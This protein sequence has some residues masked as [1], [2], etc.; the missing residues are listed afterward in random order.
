MRGKAISVLLM[1]GLL[2][3]VL[4]APAGPRAHSAGPS[5]LKEV[6][7]SPP[8]TGNQVLLRIGGPYSFSLIQ[9]GAD[10]FS[11]DLN[12]V[13]A[14]LATRTP[15]G[16]TGPVKSY[17]VIPFAPAEGRTATRVEFYLK[18]PQSIRVDK[19]Q[20]G[21]RLLLENTASETAP[22]FA[23]LPA[24]LPLRDVDL[25]AL[26]AVVPHFQVPPS[27]I[28]HVAIRRGK[29]GQ[30]VVEI[31]TT[32]QSPIRP[33]RL[34]NPPRLVVDLDQTEALRSE[35]VLPS[36]SGV[37]RNVRVA[38]FRTRPSL[39]TRVV[40]NLSE[41][42]PFRIKS[43]PD[44]VRIYI[45]QAPP[46][47]AATIPEMAPIY[48][49]VDLRSMSARLSTVADSDL[50]RPVKIDLAAPES[51]SPE[52]SPAAPEAKKHAVEEP[53]I[54]PAKIL[55]AS[56]E[57]PSAPP[58]L[59]QAQQAIQAAQTVGGTAPNQG[60]LHGAGI[61][62]TPFY[63][64]RHYTGKLI[65]LD[66]RDVDIRD[67][68]RLIH[69]VSGLNVV[70]DAD[71]T[72]KITMVMDDVPWDEALDIVLKNNDLG[73]ELEG[74]VLRVAQ[75]KTLTTEAKAQ[76]SARDA[77][78]AAEPLV[79]VVRRLEYARAADEQP[80][81][82]SGSSATGGGGAQ[83]TQL[84]IPG[85]VT[86]LNGLKGV[87]SPE[88]KVVAD[89]RDNAV[90]ITDHRSQIPII[91]AVIDKLDMKS[92]QVSIQVRVILANADFT[93]TL[94]SVLSGA[95]Q[96]SRGHTNGA[97]GTGQGITGVAP[98]GPPL[99]A[100]G[101]VTQPASVAANGF[102]AFSITT[103]AA[104]YAINAA[105]TAAETRDQARTISRPTIVTQNHIQGEVQQG[106][107]IPIQTS[108]NNTIAIQYVNATLLLSVTP[109]VTADNKVFLDIYVNNAS[110]GTFSTTT[111]PS[112]NTQQATTQVLV[113]DGGTVVFGGITVTTRGRSGTYIPLLGSIPVLGNLFK[114]SSVN[115]QNQEL[116]FF[117]SPT[118]LPG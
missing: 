30:E 28:T 104:R 96:S 9:A 99:P 92:K 36:E 105:I 103:Q 62:S 69:Q 53:P 41:N 74:N 118:V 52:K 75:V 70:V 51:S 65:S 43:G 33:F 6:A 82:S 102:G 63:N 26:L 32:R 46:D 20:A 80:M 60:L 37:L 84:P 59:L 117:V 44:S 24:A 39:V 86:I 1:A 76:A 107:Q 66:L 38:Q 109:Q 34:K 61:I 87:I 54:A 71:V 42:A 115:D 13:E 50:K 110:V 8:A 64:Q 45:G 94:S 100:L 3:V 27:R 114:S 91:E 113:P 4:C 111:G 83:Q 67:F 85:V 108:I 55:L 16:W 101:S 88:G 22:A 29:D 79:T 90:I 57:T 23:P 15:A 112:I 17:R 31:G 2:L 7:I 58:M 89:P 47:R 5:L 10:H 97:G 98:T 81:Q 77:K 21:L 12:G 40:A 78:L 106:V 72:G 35:R 14:S 95:F 25:P 56:T 73:T 68:F 11:V 19:E 48:Q 49:P 18:N 93:R 116:L